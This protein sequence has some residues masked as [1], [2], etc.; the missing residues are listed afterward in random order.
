[1]TS[2]LGTVGHRKIRA[3]R[4]ASRRALS[5]GTSDAVR[6]HETNL[7]RGARAASP[8]LGSPLPL[9]MPA[10]VTGWPSRARRC[11]SGWRRHSERGSARQS[12]PPQTWPALPQDQGDRTLFAGDGGRRLCPAA[13]GCGLMSGHFPVIPDLIRQAAS[14]SDVTKQ[15]GF[16]DQV[17]EDGSA[18]KYGFPGQAQPLSCCMPAQRRSGDRRGGRCNLNAVA[19]VMPASSSCSQ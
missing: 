13:G 6:H 1:M 5:I 10:P 15:N 14:S 4:K 9:S 12:Q 17:R 2:P 3:L 18:R 7:A 11:R 16:P 8:L 19:G